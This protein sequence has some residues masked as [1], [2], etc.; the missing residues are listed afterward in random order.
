[1]LVQNTECETV[2][3]QVLFKKLSMLNICVFITPGFV[4]LHPAK[5]YME[6]K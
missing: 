1:M 5:S 4:E 2:A 6:W 3:H